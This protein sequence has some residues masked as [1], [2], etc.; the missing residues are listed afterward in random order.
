VIIADDLDPARWLVEHMHTF[1]VDLGSLLPAVFPAYAR[2][3][4]P[5]S[6]GGE[7]VSWA[8]IA[9]TNGKV[10]HPQMQFTHLIGYPSRYS[11][12]YRDTQ[13]GL[14]DEAPAVGTLPAGAAASLA[15]I[16]A[17][18][19]PDIGNCWFA[20]WDGHGDLDPSFQGRPTFEL[21]ARHYHLAH[22]PLAAATRSVGAHDFWRVSWNLWWPDDHSWCVATEIDLDSTYLGASEAC[23][24]EVA[25][26]PEL[27]AVRIDVSA[28]VT[29]DSDAVNVAPAPGPGDS[30]AP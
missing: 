14:F 6:N 8:S 26:S 28:G 29:A 20:V 4:H 22:G 13:P 2:V 19:T 16:L 3:F 21:P 17:R 24:E 9:R 7:P 18:H 30:V 23:V 10:A 1:A 27:E 12:G 5:A 11:S 25:A 15:R